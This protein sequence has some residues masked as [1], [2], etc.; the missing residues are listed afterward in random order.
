MP[1]GTSAGVRLRRPAPAIGVLVAMA[2]LCGVPARV[3]AQRA[4]TAPTVAAAASLN[5]ALLDVAEQF[6]RDRGMRVQLVFGAS[7]TFT[8]QIQDGAP[9]EMFLAADEEFPNR[10]TA[11]GLTQ[12]RRRGLRHRPPRDLRAHG[13]AAD[14]GRA[15]R[16]PRTTGQGGR[17]HAVRDR[18]SRTWR[19]TAAPRKPCSASA[20]CGMRCAPGSCS[21]TPSRR[22][23]S[24]RRRGT[25]SAVSWRIRWCSS[26]GFADRGTYA[27][28]P[29][30]DHPPLRQRMVLLKR[31]GT[32]GRAVLR[33]SSE[34]QPRARFCRSTASRCQN[35]RPWTGRHSRVS[36][37]LGAGT[38]ADPPAVRRLAGPP[39]GRPTR[40][41]ASCWSRRSSP[42]RSSCRRRSWAS[43][44]S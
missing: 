17:G 34:R 24:L 19:R 18:Q 28:I 23:R 22:P 36:L 3:G 35:S 27:V 29:P 44:C 15:S 37:R 41:A 6:A 10:L 20:G 25:P 9:F 38:I 42:C 43:T 12:G 2:L 4:P 1:G 5:P 16:R 8:R 31:A 32:D 39:A 11:A 33:L 14:H 40:S 26:P 7:G 13:L 30:S 21:A